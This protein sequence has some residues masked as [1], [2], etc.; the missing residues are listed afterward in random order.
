MW[1]AQQDH[2][3]TF[4]TWPTETIHWLLGLSETAKCVGV[5]GPSSSFISDVIVCDKVCGTFS[6]SFLVSEKTSQS[7]HH[8]TLTAKPGTVRGCS[9]GSINHEAEECTKAVLTVASGKKKPKALG[10]FSQCSAP[11]GS[12][13]FLAEEEGRL[14]LR[15]QP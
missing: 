3:P 13:S 2:A 6:Y 14:T 9:V 10:F 1:A 5:A 12:S 11:V 8:I 7:T 15:S 4:Q